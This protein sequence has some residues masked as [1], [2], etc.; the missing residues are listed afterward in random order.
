[1]NIHKKNGHMIDEWIQRITHVVESLAEFY[2]SKEWTSDEALKCEICKKLAWFINVAILQRPNFNKKH[3]S[4]ELLALPNLADLWSRSDE[5][6][7]RP[8]WEKKPIGK[9]KLLLEVSEQTQ[10]YKRIKCDFNPLESSNITFPIIYDSVTMAKTMIIGAER[11]NKIRAWPIR[12][13]CKFR[14]LWW[15]TP[16]ISVSHWYKTY[17]RQ[18]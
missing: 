18:R 12:P 2:K 10:Q 4:D 8:F 3:L 6:N 7:M 14:L 9:T 5:V 17:D 11:K 13:N 16:E 15:N 1:M